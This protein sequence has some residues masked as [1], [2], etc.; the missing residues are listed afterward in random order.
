MAVED[1]TSVDYSLVHPISQHM[2]LCF[3]TLSQNKSLKKCAAFLALRVVTSFPVNCPLS[4]FHH[5]YCCFYALFPLKL[6]LNP[7]CVILKD[8]LRSN[9]LP[10]QWFSTFLMSMTL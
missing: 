6:I 4:F 9:R 1:M 2:S 10:S 5:K 7:Q 8:E 3:L